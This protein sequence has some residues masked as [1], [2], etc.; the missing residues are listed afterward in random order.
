MQRQRG[1]IIRRG[2]KYSIKYRTPT[3][4][5]KWESG[6]AN[7]A[8]AQTRLNEVLRELGIGEYIEP[9]Q[10]T[11]KEFAEEWLTSRVS[12]RGATLSAYRSI[13]KLWLIPAFGH[14]KISEIQLGDVQKMVTDLS[15]NLSAKTLKNCITLLR[16]MLVGKKG[17]SAVKR[18]YIR[19]D[20]TR[21]LEL[22]SRH[23][24]LI[25]PP[26]IEQVWKLID[27]AA[28]MG[29]LGH[30]IVY[31]DA[32]TGLRRNEIL[33]LEF[34]DIDWFTREV[35]VSKAISKRPARDGVHKWEWVIGP[36]KSSKSIRRVALPE[37][38][39]QLLSAFRQIRGE[40]A[41]YIF[42]NAQEAFLDPDYFN[43]YIFAPVAKATELP[44]T[45]FH[46]L[47]HFFASMLI[48]QGESPK[49]ICD[50]MG[51]SSVQI[52]F[53]IYGHLFPQAREEAAAK[54]QKAML[55]GRPKSFGSSLVAKPQ[56][57][58]PNKPSR[59]GPNQRK[60]N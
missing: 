24:K 3:G 50:Q 58:A 12:I 40:K 34:T 9:K 51:H 4:K 46:D 27:A 47:R 10:A 26:S 48:A 11:F 55:A 20:P 30:A 19:H 21:G 14:R 56:N 42:S 8:A 7:K 44:D 59:N 36:P 35:S 16:V 45:R 5:Q 52:T 53:D 17:A 18:G 41:K 13:A 33:A 15:T 29:E 28:A 23:S 32:F 49:Y 38:V 39:V 25:V 37:T 54:F 22:P 6:F 43:E 57:R 60:S 2:S 1:A 31:M